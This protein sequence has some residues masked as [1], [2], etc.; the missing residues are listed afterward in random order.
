M[1]CKKCGEEI[2]SDDIGLNRKFFGRSVSEFFCISCLAEYFKVSVN[3][4]KDLIK[5]W[6]EAGCTLFR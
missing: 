6:R 5:N 1:R 4:L 2:F 3:Y